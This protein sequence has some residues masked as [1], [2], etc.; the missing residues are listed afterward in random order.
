M[1]KGTSH[2]LI[3]IYSLRLAWTGV[4][5]ALPSFLKFALSRAR[6][7]ND[8]GAREPRLWLD[9]H[10]FDEAGHHVPPL[11]LLTLFIA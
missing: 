1:G 11:P 3:F 9:R 6:T 4:L 5:E 7:D 10:A 2:G 8:D